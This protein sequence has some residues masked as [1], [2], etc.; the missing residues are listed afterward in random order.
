MNKEK[1]SVK[2]NPLDEAK[3]IGYVEGFSDG[4]IELIKEL[5]KF[6]LLFKNWKAIYNKKTKQNY[7]VK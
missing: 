3:I 4:R 2:Q 5:V 7:L 1:N 6:K